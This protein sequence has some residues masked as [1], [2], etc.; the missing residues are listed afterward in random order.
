LYFCIEGGHILERKPI[1]N[2][3][4]KIKNDLVKVDRKE[5]NDL[6]KEVAKE[7]NI[8]FGE[9]S[10]MIMDG[11][12]DIAKVPFWVRTGI[13]ALDY[14]VGGKVHPGLPGGRI[15][16]V[17]GEE[18]S[19]KT[20]LTIYFLRKVVDTMGIGVFQDSEHSLSEERVNQI[21]LDKRKVIYLQPETMEEVFE[22]Q[23][24][25]I[26]LIR[27][28]RSK[29]PLVIGWDS[30]A[31]T[32]TSAELEGEYGSEVMG[33]HARLM[34]QSLRKIKG[35][36]KKE[37]VLALYVNQ[38]RDKI[39]VRFGEKTSTFGGRALK[40]YASVRI[41]V[42]IIEKIKESEGKDSPVVGIRVRATVRK[43]K[44]APPFKT[45]EFII[46]FDDRCVDEIGAVL[47][48]LKM[49]GLAGET[50]GW[51]EIEGKKYRFKDAWELLNEDRDLFEKYYELC[52]EV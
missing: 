22:Q 50:Q 6:V 49:N 8:K 10:A 18:S 51:Y 26:N 39:G 43:N 16:E 15:V 47:E 44:V 4:K 41:E 20:T 28:K 35:L 24:H 7:L 12:E 11:E 45:A 14:A 34:S 33:Q 42:A 21:G 31:S 9:G 23:E 30:V 3:D 25:I 1:K 37:N 13:P 2:T 46:Y 40:F 27:Q 5:E 29:T 17:Y 52:Y 19:G 38:I 48:W 32:P 36:I